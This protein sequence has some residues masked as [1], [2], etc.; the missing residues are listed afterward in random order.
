MQKKQKKVKINLFFCICIL[1]SD[2]R[3]FV[4]ITM[5]CCANH[6]FSEMK[7]DPRNPMSFS[8]FGEL[9]SKMAQ[10]TIICNYR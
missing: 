8:T 1:I 10:N 4:E 2:N 7:I 5:V 3:R 9:A 6:Y